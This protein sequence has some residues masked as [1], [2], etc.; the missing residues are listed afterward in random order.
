MSRTEALKNA[1]KRHRSGIKRVDVS[2][3]ETETELYQKLL[4]YAEKENVSVNNA[5]KTALSEMLH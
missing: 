4:K 5:V 3:A 2:F 1:Q